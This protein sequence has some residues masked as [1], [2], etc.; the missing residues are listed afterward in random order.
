M[1]EEQ[2][3]PEESLGDLAQ[4][5]YEESRQRAYELEKALEAYIREKPVKSLLIAAGAGM[6]LGLLWKR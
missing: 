5:S 6:L 3:K 4:S 1:P 2:G